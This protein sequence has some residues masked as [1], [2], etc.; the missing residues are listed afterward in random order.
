MWMVSLRVIRSRQMSLVLTL[1][2]TALLALLLSACQIPDPFAAS[3][4]ASSNSASSIV[5][6]PS[7]TDRGNDGFTIS[8][9]P[10]WKANLAGINDAIFMRLAT[11]TMLEVKVTTVQV[12]PDAV[13]AGQQPTATDQQQRRITVTQRSIAGHLAIDVFTPYYLVP[14]PS[15]Q[16]PNSGFPAIAGGR[17]IVMATTNSAGTTNVYTFTVQYATDDKAQMTPASHADDPTI[18]A[19]LATFQLP[20]PVDPVVTQP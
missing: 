2:V 19:M 13:L 4:H 14:T 6:W 17:T 11:G 1:S 15:V 18:D 9:P 8:Y 10:S 20:Q 3:G 12:S 5:T 7:F 16:M